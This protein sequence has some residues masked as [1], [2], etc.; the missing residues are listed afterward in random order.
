MN[1]HPFTDNVQYLKI[2]N[3]TNKKVKF[4]EKPNIVTVNIFFNLTFP[5]NLNHI[6]FVVVYIG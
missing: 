4:K 5:R 3:N 6:S 1:R 2:K